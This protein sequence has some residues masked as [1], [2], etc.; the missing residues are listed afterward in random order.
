MLQ[1]KARNKRVSRT[2]SLWPSL[3]L[4][5]LEDRMCPAGGSGDVLAGFLAAPGGFGTNGILEIQTDPNGPSGLGGV[6]QITL[7]LNGSMLRVAGVH[8]I[9]S[10]GLFATTVNS[11]SFADFPLSSIT[12]IKVDFGTGLASVNASNFSIPGNFTVNYGFSGDTIALTNFNSNTVNIFFSTALGTGTGTGGTGSGGTGTGSGGT[13]TGTGSGGTGTGSGGTGTGTGSGGTGTGS[14][15]TGTGTGSGGTGTGSGTGNTGGGATGSGN[16]TGLLIDPIILTGVHTGAIVVVTGPASD[17]V[18]L[19]NCLSGTTSIST[20]GLGNDSI[21]IS[22]STLGNLMATAG[23]GNNIISLN[24]SLMARAVITSGRG[25]NTLTVS[26]DTFSSNAAAPTLN[27]SVGL[28]GQN[29]HTVIL[30]NLLFR[31]NAAN[32]LNNGS[33]TVAVGNANVANPTATPAI[34][35]SAVVLAT[36]SGVNAATATVGSNWGLVKIDTLTARSLTETVGNGTTD[37]KL[38]A[39]TVEGPVGV[40]VGDNT[41]N[42]LLS[43]ISTFVTP[44]DLALGRSSDLSL[45]TGNGT[46]TITLSNFNVGR[47][48]SIVNGNGNTMFMI[49]NGTVGQDMT[50]LTGNGSITAFLDTITILNEL[51]AQAGIGTNAFAVDNT[52]CAFGEIDG[53][54]G[55]GNTYWNLGGNAGFFTVDFTGFLVGP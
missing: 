54:L 18:T 27:V 24:G 7:A 33:L 47:N 4:E 35:A 37:L 43:N 12:S 5:T 31:T 10:A 53:G 9:T 13:G 14:G 2:T 6:S 25:A 16:N 1:G 17:S 39:L 44:L 51:F 21:S 52:T 46:Q 29:T 22:G 19:S 49:S 32:V 3:K 55:G 26:N 41:Q 38:N 40:T 48:L 42:V 50:L 45:R 36:I 28:G 20:P 11:T 30:S 15:G 34:P 8:T 23:D